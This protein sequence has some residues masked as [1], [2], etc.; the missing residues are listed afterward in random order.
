VYIDNPGVSREHLR[1]ERAGSGL[2]EV[3]DLGTANGSLL[4]DEPLLGRVPVC[5]GDRMGVGKFTLTVQ[6]DFGHPQPAASQPAFGDQATTVL[7]KE[8]LAKVLQLHRRTDAVPPRPLPAAGFPAPTVVPAPER[9]APQSGGKLTMGTVVVC[10]VAAFALG[11]A[12]GAFLVMM[13]PF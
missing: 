4:N 9:A 2:Y 1:I 5:D 7:S 3:V 6:Y 8:D 11:V 12:T 10:A 13:K